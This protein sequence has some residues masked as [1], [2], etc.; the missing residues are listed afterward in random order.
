M[1]VRIPESV[2]S[3]AITGTEILESEINLQ[4]LAF[5]R[6]TNHYDTQALTWKQGLLE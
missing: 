5:L 1:G 3:I 4:K 2:I 6:I